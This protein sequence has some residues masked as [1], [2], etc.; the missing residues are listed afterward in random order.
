MSDNVRFEL[1][2]I[3]QTDTKEKLNSPSTGHKSTNDQ[4]GLEAYTLFLKNVCAFKKIDQLPT[5]ILFDD[6]CQAQ[7]LLSKNVVWHRSCKRKFASDRLE[8]AKQK[9][10][11]NKQKQKSFRSSEKLETDHCFLCEKASDKK[12]PLHKVSTQKCSDNISHCI[13]V[14]EDETLMAKVAGLDMIAAEI[15]YHKNCLTRLHNLCRS[16]TRRIVH[17]STDA[18]ANSLLEK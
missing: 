3:C 1:C 10:P 2:L 12:N 4:T 14:V 15:K 18:F 16:K 8:R 13:Q 9:R 7:D 11:S 17:E 5:P 6:N